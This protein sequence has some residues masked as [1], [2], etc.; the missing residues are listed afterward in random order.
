MQPMLMTSMV[1]VVLL[2]HPWQSSAQHANRLASARLTTGVD[3]HIYVRLF[4]APPNLAIQAPKQNRS[5]IGTH[6]VMFGALAGAAGG[7]L[8]GATTGHP[9]VEESF[10]GRAG[11]IQI[12]TAAGA[13]V[14]ALAGLVVAWIR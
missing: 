5:W 9:C 8:I 7:A 12:G 13:G 11:M 10:C 14:G 4:T 2:A 3:E 1:L 6:P